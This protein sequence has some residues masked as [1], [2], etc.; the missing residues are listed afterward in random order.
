M[1]KVQYLLVKS[2]NKFRIFT[3]TLLYHYFILKRYLTFPIRNR[4]NSHDKKVTD[5]WNVHNPAYVFERVLL[6]YIL[7]CQ[8]TPYPRKNV[9]ESASVCLL[10]CRN[11][12]ENIPKLGECQ[13]LLQYS[14][15]LLLTIN[16]DQKIGRLL[17][18]RS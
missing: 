15:K 3:V 2:S 12:L 17:N 4:I 8:D 14:E 7:I 16:L 5:Y 6:V 10:M 13:Y 1:F 18:Q 9:I 11:I